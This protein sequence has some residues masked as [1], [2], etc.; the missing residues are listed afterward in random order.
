MADEFHSGNRIRGSGLTEPG[1]DYSTPYS[2]LRVHT[3]IF[4]RDDAIEPIVRIVK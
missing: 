2:V 4:I 3:G 1:W